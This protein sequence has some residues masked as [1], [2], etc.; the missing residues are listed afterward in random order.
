[1]SVAPELRVVL[2]NNR[3]EGPRDLFT[4]EDHIIG[5]NHEEIE[6]LAN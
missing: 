2:R 3:L 4:S 1:M 6:L 5:L